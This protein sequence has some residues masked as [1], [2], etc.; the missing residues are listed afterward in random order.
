MNNMIIDKKSL[1]KIVDKHLNP[2]EDK[3]Y[4]LPKELVLREIENLPPVED[5]YTDE[6]IIENRNDVKAY[7]SG[8]LKEFVSAENDE[9]KVVILSNTRFLYIRKNNINHPVPMHFWLQLWDSYYKSEF[10]INK[11]QYEK[12]TQKEKAII[13]SKIQLS[14]WIG[15]EYYTEYTKF[16]FP[17]EYDTWFY[18][19]NELCESKT[20]Y[21][22]CINEHFKQKLQNSKP[23]SINLTGNDIFNTTTTGMS[24]YD[25]MLHK[26][27]IA[28]NRDPVEYF[29]TNKGLV[30]EI[31]YMS[32]QEYLEESYKIHRKFS[33]DYG[34]PQIPF[35]T[36][37]KTNIDTELINEY[38]ERT[39]EG[40]KMPIP[41]L[42]YDKLTQEGRH[43]AVVAKELDVEEIPVLIVRT[44]EE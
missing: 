9:Y 22:S 5:E 43:R 39:L 20:D 6:D 14:L 2:L 31:T 33:I 26:E 17:K 42:D 24:Y 1:Q 37:L 19:I 16:Y 29:K 32:P 12:L 41:V 28:G 34:I 40:S 3:V 8:K 35:E 10:G 11:E 13:E 23:Q 21:W 18:E 36:Y 44:Y 38:I 27:Y 25:A 4:T 30:F 15:K 7:L